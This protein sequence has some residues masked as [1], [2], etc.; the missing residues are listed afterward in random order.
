MAEKT[1][2]DRLRSFLEYEEANGAGSDDTPLYDVVGYDLTYG[3]LRQ[4]LVQSDHRAA[5]LRVERDRTA[6]AEKLLAETTAE[7][8]QLRRQLDAAEAQP[9]DHNSDAFEALERLHGRVHRDFN[10]DASESAAPDDE[11]WARVMDDLVA[12]ADEVYLPLA[13]ATRAAPQRGPGD[14]ETDKYPPHTV[15]VTHLPPGFDHQDRHEH[16]YVVGNDTVGWTSHQVEH[17]DACHRLPY[18]RHCWLDENWY[19]GPYRYDEIEPGRYQATRVSEMVGDHNG[20]FSHMDEYVHYERTGD[21]P[22]QDAEPN[23]LESVVTEALADIA[24]TPADPEPTPPAA[25]WLLE[26]GDD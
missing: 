5:A 10:F 23:P 21:A 8:D 9:C 16:E 25:P 15:T 3:D 18:G 7:R 20:E 6:S 1:S 13:D 11:R 4:V 26:A 19:E 12:F 22:G 2:A 14:D 24:T 17:P